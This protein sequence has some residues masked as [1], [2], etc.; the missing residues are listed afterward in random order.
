MSL[1]HRSSHRRRSFSSDRY[2]RSFRARNRWDPSADGSLH[3][4]DSHDASPSVL[5]TRE[6]GRRWNCPRAEGHLVEAVEGGRPAGSSESISRVRPATCGSD[7]TSPSEYCPVR[8]V[9]GAFHSPPS[10]GGT[11]FH[12]RSEF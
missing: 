6:R 1:K 4:P 12:T 10:R 9:H 5:A 3:K 7:K 2:R 8:E 11:G